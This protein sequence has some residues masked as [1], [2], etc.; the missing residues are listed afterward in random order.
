M[1]PKHR[2]EHPWLEDYPN[3]KITGG[4]FKVRTPK[5][6]DPQ[7][8]QISLE[9]KY[10]G[11]GKNGKAAK[12][13][14]GLYLQMMRAWEELRGNARTEKLLK[15]I[16]IATNPHAGD[17][18]LF[19]DYS[20][21][22]RKNCLPHATK[23][24]KIPLGERTKKDY[25]GFL[26]LQIE[27]SKNQ[28]LDKFISRVTLQDLRGL[29]KPWLYKE[30]TY[31]HI[32]AVLVRVFQQAV[33]EGLRPDNPARQIENRDTANRNVYID[34]DAFLNITN[35]LSLWEAKA[36]DLL[37][38]V[39]GRPANVLNLNEQN[40]VKIDQDGE[41]W[42]ELHFMGEKT[43]Q[44][45]ELV[46]NDDLT[47]LLQWFRDWKRGQCIL[48]DH[49]VVYPLTSRHNCIGKPITRGYLSEKFKLA[50]IAA[51]YWHWEE[52]LS[53][54]TKTMKQYKTA[55]YQLKDIRPKAI[56]DENLKDSSNNKGAHRSESGRRVYI[57]LPDPIRMET[58]ISLISKRQD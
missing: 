13:A 20:E 5:D 19:R 27:G 17:G 33:D 34:D 55:D 57:R 44:P 26:R 18:T 54:Q 49:F 15:K 50:C 11:R 3:L 24:K 46:I 29:L 36:C 12:I 7:R 56:T 14:T 16:E 30:T 35:N 4:I 40:V 42:Q 10:D 21:Y 58:K 38:L 8:R 47:D 25:D 41:Q 31:N 52:K 32:R 37:Y 28:C 22:Y 6:I 48:S 53:P 2:T 51:G 45:I 43:N 1:T 9:V 39:S 23:R